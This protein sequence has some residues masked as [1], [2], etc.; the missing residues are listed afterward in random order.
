MKN[1]YL[2]LVA[3]LALS[4]CSKDDSTTQPNEPQTQIPISISSGVWTKVTDTEYESGDKVGIYITN[5]NNTTATAL[6]STG[7]HADNVGFTLNNG[8][9]GA[10][11]DL[12]WK[13]KETNADFYC[14]FPYADAVSNVTSYSFT[15]Q[16]N[17]SSESGYKASEFLW[18]KTANV[19]PTEEAVVIL[20]DRLM[21]CILIT[22]EAGA[23][24]TDEEFAALD[25]TVVVQN[26]M[27]TATI[28]LSTGVATATGSTS[29]I[30]PQKTDT[31]EYRVIVVPQ[32]IAATN[33]IKVTIEGIDYQLNVT[34]T[35]VANTQHPC[36]VTIAK[37]S[38]GVNVGI[39]GWDTDDTDF[40]GSAQ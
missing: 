30:T 26:T 13:D 29:D 22:L 33:L 16:S 9:W 6:A 5:Y 24:Y 21:S 14:Y 38:E 36:T 34:K 7:N 40:G 12:Y 32:S 3:F 18:G 39:G 27:P 25:K 35:F 15:V 10:D 17:Q 20:T 37:T 2:L 11:S 31:D 23:G 19:A 8:E 1:L 4:S 28:N